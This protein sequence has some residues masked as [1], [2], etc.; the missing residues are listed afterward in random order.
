VTFDPKQY[1][2]RPGLL[3]LG[4]VVYTAWG[5]HCDI[6]PYTGWVMGYSAST[7]AQT[8][9][10]NVVPNGSEGGIWMSQAGPATDGQGNIYVLNGNGSFS[11]ILNSSGFPRNQ[12]FGNAFLKLSTSSGLA[13]ADYF[14]MDNEQTENNTDT[15]LGS[16]GVLVLPDLVDNTGTVWHLAAGAG[17]D[18]NLYL[19]NRDNM[20]KFSSRNNRIYQE[21]PG[22]FPGGIWS[23]PAYFNNKLYYGPVNGPILSFAFSNA[24]LSTGPVSQTTTVFGYPGVT[25]SIS[26]N[27]TTNG[28]VWAV[29][30]VNPEVLHAYDAAT[31]VELYNSNQAGSRDHFGSGNKF[32]TPTIVNGKVYAATTSGVGVFGVLP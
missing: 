16:G 20:G 18:S 28:I 13:V 6:Q 31:L 7:L 4:G 27:N 12:N 29:E 32:V 19:V 1:K 11:K 25:P 8:T 9:V 21:L 23:M 2:S 22:V 3:L 14:E 30:N 26:A 17:K 24:K 10:L 15:D 5:S